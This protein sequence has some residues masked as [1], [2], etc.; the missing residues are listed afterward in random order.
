[1]DLNTAAQAMSGQWVPLRRKTD[2]TIEG[3]VISY[4]ARPATF[5]GAPKLSR[6]TGQQRTEWVFTVQTDDDIVK[7][8]LAE[9]GQRAIAAAIKESGKPANVPGDHIKIAVKDDPATATEQPT[10]VVRWTTDT[11]PLA[12]V[13][14]EEEEPF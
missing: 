2:G 6:K 14:V 12:E 5:D 10:Y 8:S 11:T 13:A 9:S 3:R 7:F 4:E 1:V